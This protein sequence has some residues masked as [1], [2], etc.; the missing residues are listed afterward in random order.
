MRRYREQ[1][2]EK[3]NEKNKEKISCSICNKMLSRSSMAR[4]KR[5]QH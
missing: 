3:I 1:H 4:H 2:R 5:I